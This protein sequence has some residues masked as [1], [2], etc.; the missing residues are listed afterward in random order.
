MSV[1]GAS[2]AQ[3]RQIR[4]Y[5]KRSHVTYQRAYQQQQQAINSQDAEREMQRL[6]QLQSQAQRMA[7]YQEQIRQ[8]NLSRAAIQAKAERTKR[9]IQAQVD[10]RLARQK[11]ARGRLVA[12][13]GRRAIGL[14]KQ[15]ADDTYKFA[16][17]RDAKKKEESILG[18]A[19]AAVGSVANIVPGLSPVLELAGR[20]QE[21]IAQIYHAAKN[22]E[23]SGEGLFGQT[24]AG[25][26]QIPGLGLLDDKGTSRTQQL[27]DYGRAVNSR[28]EREAL[29][30][31]GKYASPGE[32]IS[33]KAAEVLEGQ[34]LENY[35]RFTN[36]GG[37][38]SN[39]FVENIVSAGAD[40]TFTIGTD[41]LSYI[42]GGISRSGLSTPTRS[43]GTKALSSAG[44]NLDDATR[45]AIAEAARDSFLTTTRR[46]RVIESEVV[47]VATRASDVQSLE[48]ALPGI[49]TTT[50]KEIAGASTKVEAEGIIKRA[51]R[52]GEYAPDISMRRQALL[53]T[54]GRG[55]KAPAGIGLGRRVVRESQ[56]LFDVTG[57]LRRIATNKRGRIAVTRTTTAAQARRAATKSSLRTVGVRSG[58]A[59]QLVADSYA[60]LTPFERVNQAL[61]D[62]S[63]LDP[64]VSDIVES[65]IEGLL[66][67]GKISQADRAAGDYTA[68]VDAAFAD[69]AKGQK[70]LDALL[71]AE[72]L[73]ATARGDFG[74]E[75]AK[76]LATELG[77]GY[78][79]PGLA[80]VQQVIERAGDRAGLS[81]PRAKRF[82]KATSKHFDD[83]SD[84]IDELGE[85]ALREG[86][87]GEL[88]RIR[89]IKKKSMQADSLRRLQRTVGLARRSDDVAQDAAGIIERYGDALARRDELV[90]GARPGIGQRL[91]PVRALGKVVTSLD[92]TVAPNQIRFLSTENIELATQGRV[93]AL[94][95]YMGALHMDDAT[96]AAFRQASAEVATEK[97]LY[98][99][100]DRV[101]QVHADAQGVP[102]D[103]LSDLLAATR[104]GQDRRILFGVKPTDDGVERLRE[105]QN[106]SQLSEVV[107]L[108]D[109]VDINK[110]VRQLRRAMDDPDKMAN[111]RQY[112]AEPPQT[113]KL[114]N[115]AASIHRTWKLMVVTNLYMP[116][117]GG[118]AGFI[119]TDGDFTDKLKGGFQWA[120]LGAL[121]PS[122]YVVRIG[123]EE[124]ARRVLVRS[125][126]PKEFI[127]GVAKWS[128]QRGVIKPL[129]SAHLL[130]SGDPTGSAWLR[131]E[132]STHATGEFEAMALASTDGVLAKLSRKDAR[133]ID[134]WQRIVNNEI[135]AANGAIDRIL[136]G[137]KAGHITK[138]EA[139]D[140]V[141]AFLKSE[142]GKLWW[143]RWQG[144]HATLA[145]TGKARGLA[146][147]EEA[148]WRQAEFID[149]YVPED[150]AR[151]RLP[152]M[153]ADFQKV[154]ASMFKAK[155]KDKT[156]PAFIHAE[157]TWKI[158]R[159]RTF[160]ADVGKVK[161]KLTDK[162]IFGGPTR[163]V[164]RRPLARA[165]YKDEYMKL[166]RSGVDPERAAQLADQRAIN[167]TNDIMFNQSNESRF[168]SK[169]DIVFPFQQPREELVRVWAPLIFNNKIRSIQ[170]TKLGAQTL[171]NGAS[172]GVFYEYTDP[173]TGEKEWRMKVPGSAPLS[174]ALGGVNAQFDFGLKD[175]MFM[176]QDSYSTLGIPAPG[177][178]FFTVAQRMYVNAFPEHYTNLHPVLKEY[179]FPFGAS[180]RFGRAEPNRL[181]MGL[182]G[183][184]A[185]W[186]FM[187]E[188][189]QKEEY[190]KVQQEMFL[191]LY[192][193]NVKR[194]ATGDMRWPSDE[195]VDKAVSAYFKTQAL[196]GA[197]WP[198]R[199]RYVQP[200]EELIEAAKQ[201]YLDRN[202][203]LD[204]FGFINDHPNFAPFLS[205]RNEYVGPDD[206]KHWSRD[207]KA[208]A[209]DYTRHWAE[210]HSLQE[211]RAEIKENDLTSQ[212]WAERTQIPFKHPDYEI[213]DAYIAWEEKWGAKLPSVVSS[214]RNNYFRDQELHRIMQ[215]ADGQFKDRALDRWRKRYDVTY[216]SYQY[217]E[218]R[219]QKEGWKVDYWRYSRSTDEVLADV[220]RL[221][222]L[223]G[224]S[225]EAAVLA[226]NPAEQIKYWKA[227]QADLDYFDGRDDPQDILDRYYLYKDRVSDVYKK[228]PKLKDTGPDDRTK[229]EKYLSQWRG[230]YGDAI[231][232]AFDE[233]AV[234]SKRFDELKK[235]GKSWSAEGQALYEKRSALYDMVKALK[236]QQY[237]ELPGF[238]DMQADVE[239]ASALLRDGKPTRAYMNAI[240][241]IMARG[242]G[243]GGYVPSNE[244]LGVLNMPDEVREAYVADLQQQLSL[245]SVKGTKGK[246]YWEWLTDFQKDYLEKNL[247][248]DLVDEWKDDD[249]DNAKGRGGYK[250][251]KR[252]GGRSYYKNSSERAQ[253]QY[254]YDLFKQYN[255]RPE[256][257]EPPPAYAEYLLLPKNPA[258]RNQF[259]DQHPEVGEWIS[260]GPM[261]NMPTHLRFIVQ[262][263]MVKHGKWE[264]EIIGDREATDISFAR[265]ALARWN[266]RGTMQRPLAYDTWLQM[267][268]GAAKAKFLD[269][270]PEVQNWLRLGPMS[271]MPDAYQDVVR[272]IMMRYGEWTQDTSPLGQVIKEYYST[273]SYAR[274]Q[275]LEEHPELVSYWSAIRTPEEKKMAQKVD[276]YFSI[277]D[278][279]ARRAFLLI[280]Q[281]VKDHFVE[282]RSRRYEKF[283]T[284]VAVYMGANPELFTAY[285]ERQEDILNDLM[286]RY[287]QPTLLREVA[288]LRDAKPTN[289]QRRRG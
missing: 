75:A 284:Q 160:F 59:R 5:Q 232:A 287:A 231:S 111:I 21:E 38:R 179:L 32:F 197:V 136:L 286:L 122:R 89:G 64:I 278:P 135:N 100:V 57:K 14:R 142:D 114:R 177:G 144:A 175:V 119:G 208:R 1:P 76:Q 19:K 165:L 13:A 40:L 184:P 83:V 117:A 221:A 260:L 96:R 105:V 202:G 55:L 3:Q 193:E 196:L 288:P 209:D 7:Q 174:R 254:A 257:A 176:T 281:D 210:R 140:L 78:R 169:V 125:F 186:E 227:E 237:K 30:A 98:D 25:L 283:L 289:R 56:G 213:A 9:I 79:K 259:L 230:K 99:L 103:I 29:R 225:R 171:E 245:P 34:A 90:G 91:N 63:G 218:E 48:R 74:E 195:E 164:Q 161:D 97:D 203:E 54:T 61:N 15:L 43:A 113:R 31:E 126:S 72:T 88:A 204:Y 37:T 35:R 170:L 266:R 275:Y 120:A 26:L 212:A 109:P 200:Y 253:L 118:F 141:K 138:A 82:A 158:P 271:N 115:L 216:K 2:P 149:N 133:Y 102:A 272:D 273:P 274:E 95:S 229:T 199:T 285:L 247:P 17:Q 162:F 236:N 150:I 45:R 277:Q 16:G 250:K 243:N 263:I 10:A 201:P 151:V 53:A 73:I 222:R 80:N 87:Q 211:F 123:I 66:P 224:V 166:V 46:G 268:T 206:L 52:T 192:H 20:P 172:L 279:T 42:P 28:D 107:P 228:Y 6:F 157:N 33:G 27:F 282:S 159:P 181:W 129:M 183:R 189:E 145:K 65:T 185:P 39:E 81:L 62:V 235:A 180:G 41:P 240:K 24:Q 215:M 194:G 214:S 153:D 44:K 77:I 190:K 128:A 220:K 11:Q 139:D 205:S 167:L 248:K 234:V 242:I 71:E 191:T 86:L 8:K 106:L 156:A 22:A 152:A 50:A 173:F 12:Q 258:V 70:A 68:W 51:L 168:S 110:T 270:H 116:V 238:L 255:K 60:S 217:I 67:S 84:E 155:V 101:L 267:P 58:D 18:R 124:T 108:P 264:G 178:P 261:A 233:I 92:E 269:Q 239:A 148:F 85:D 246:L 121:G 132:L 198:A 280:H 146:A 251:W 256:G 94:D 69:G 223:R 130:S 104:H 4:E 249:P 137:L 154:P 262:N 265:D 49:P 252:W 36:F 244:E 127:P 47:K 163:T 207:E 276:Q 134:S 112:L 187:H 241:N 23:L 182:V 131:N 143:R 147:K 219:L 188:W 226:L 93:E